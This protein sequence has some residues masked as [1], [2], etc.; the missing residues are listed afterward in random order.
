MRRRSHL[1]EAVI[2]YWIIYKLYSLIN[3]SNLISMFLFEWNHL[4]YT[5]C[6][7]LSI[8][9]FFKHL[10]VFMLFLYFWYPFFCKANV[11]KLS[12]FLNKSIYCRLKILGH[13]NNIYCMVYQ[14]LIRKKFKY[15]ICLRNALKMLSF[16]C[17]DSTINF[18]YQCI[19]YKFFQH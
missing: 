9:D 7:K 12:Y 13:A 5:N 15:N 3:M 10:Q 6:A 8:P 2:T 17:F 14:Y 1:N 16:R 11:H 4:L 18:R 19:L